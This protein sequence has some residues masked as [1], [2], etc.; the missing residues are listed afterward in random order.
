MLGYSSTQT[1]LEAYNHHNSLKERVPA[2][3]HDNLN[4]IYKWVNDRNFVHA[5]DNN[6]VEGW[7]W[8]ATAMVHPPMNVIRKFANET[9][10]HVNITSTV[11]KLPPTTPPKCRVCDKDIANNTYEKCK[12]SVVICKCERRW[13][14]QPCAEQLVLATPQCTVCKSYFILNPCCS[15]LRSTIAMK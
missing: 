7:E 8:L 14:H 2:E 12:F 15:T 9:D 5:L 3:F 4:Y 1:S 13:C 11:Q 10:K 6:T